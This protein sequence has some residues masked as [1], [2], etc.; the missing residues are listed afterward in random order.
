MTWGQILI[1]ALSTGTAVAIVQGIFAWIFRERDRKWR[2]QDRLHAER[3]RKT[4]IW[5]RFEFAASKFEHWTY[6]SVA[7]DMRASIAGLVGE[8]GYTMDTLA[9]Q[10]LDGIRSGPSGEWKALREQMVREYRYWA[11]GSG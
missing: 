5:Q 3:Q 7:M 1:G 6:E 8:F 4:A 2:E 9:G 10:M 11:S